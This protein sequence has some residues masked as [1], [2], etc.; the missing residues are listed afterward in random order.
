MTAGRLSLKVLICLS[1]SSDSVLKSDTFAQYDRKFSI[2]SRKQRIKGSPVLMASSNC[3]I[4][5][6]TEENFSRLLL[7]YKNCVLFSL[8]LLE[9]CV[10]KLLSLWIKFVVSIFSNY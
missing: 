1:S 10:S 2:D 7:K 8:G 4:V 3:F 5:T 9:F 6:Y